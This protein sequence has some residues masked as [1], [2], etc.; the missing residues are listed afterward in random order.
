MTPTGSSPSN[1]E[2]TG[3]SIIEADSI[4]DAEEMLKGHPHLA[5]AAGL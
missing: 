5:W 2:V 1:K 4:E 3:Y